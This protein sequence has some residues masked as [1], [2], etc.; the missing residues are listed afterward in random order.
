MAQT[1][2]VIEDEMRIARWI[3]TYL[4]KD[5]YKTLIANNGRDGLLMALR[6]NPDLVVLDIMLPEMDG[7][8]VC[9]RI[10]QESDVPIIMVTARITDEDVIRG[11]ELGA[12]DYIKKPFNPLELL[13]RIKAN[14]KRASGQ[15]GPAQHILR[16]GDLE[17]DPQ[18]KAVH[19]DGQE[20]NLTAQQFDLLEHFMRHPYQVFSRE[21]LIESVFGFDYSG[22]ERAIDVHISRLRGKIK[23]EGQESMIQTVFGL[24]YK[25][26]PE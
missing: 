26:V 17:M 2:L 11:L 10:R 22:F 4:E 15:M 13:A 7:W 19:L 16:A 21:Q 24:G 23:I 6:Q 1:I 14:L 3:Q 25:L 20:L 5:H 12:D 18:A 8:E 9:R